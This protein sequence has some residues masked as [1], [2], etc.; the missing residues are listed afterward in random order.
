MSIERNKER[1]DAAVR[2]RG[3]LTPQ[4]RAYWVLE[5]RVSYL[6]KALAV[7][8]LET[9]QPYDPLEQTLPYSPLDSVDVP[10]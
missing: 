4:S 10:Q 7:A 8:D 1:L 3:R 9:T 5:D 2:K 6:T